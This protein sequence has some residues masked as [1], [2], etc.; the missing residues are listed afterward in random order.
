MV[1]EFVLGNRLGGPCVE[2]SNC[3]LAIWR[4]CGTMESSRKEEVTGWEREL[5]VYSSDSFLPECPCHVTS[6][7]KLIL[8]QT[9]ASPMPP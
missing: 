2:G 6:H 3:S 9:Q 4:S 8:P 1:P 7:L 5:G